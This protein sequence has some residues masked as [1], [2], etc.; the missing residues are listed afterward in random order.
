MVSFVIANID[1]LDDDCKDFV[2]QRET[3]LNS[4][5]KDVCE[6]NYDQEV[7]CQSLKAY[8]NEC[9]LRGGS[10]GTWWDD[11]PQCGKSFLTVVRTFTEFHMTILDGHHGSRY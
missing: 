1:R 8:A 5:I 2:N 9:R 11:V 6:S 7:V 3:L 10:P 4:C